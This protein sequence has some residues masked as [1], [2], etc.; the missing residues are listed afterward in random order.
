MDEN[1][2]VDFNDLPGKTVSR[3]AGGGE[4][5]LLIFTDETWM[6][7]SK[8]GFGGLH[9]ESALSDYQKYEVGLITKD[10]YERIESEHHRCVQEYRDK[11]DREHYERL[12]ARFG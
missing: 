6:I 1:K 11:I 8:G 4:W 12:K 10:E 3:I 2:L 7:I 5:V 9:L